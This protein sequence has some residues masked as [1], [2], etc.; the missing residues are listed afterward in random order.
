VI[1]AETLMSVVVVNDRCTHSARGIC[2]N[3]YCS[4]KWLW[5]HTRKKS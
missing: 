4:K 2:Q 3:Q 5:M 1:D